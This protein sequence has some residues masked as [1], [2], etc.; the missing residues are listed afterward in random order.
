MKV[1]LLDVPF[2]IVIGG[3]CASLY[4]KHL[5]KRNKDWYVF[6]ILFF[7]VIFWLDII[8]SNSGVIPKP[9]FG[10]LGSVNIHPLIGTFYVL[11]YPLW[12][13]WGAERAFQIFGRSPEEEGVLW[14]F[15]LEEKGKPFKPSWKF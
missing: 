15:T 2:L 3:I 13:S 9:W 14:P 1:G 5:I 6:L 11:S 12:F 8:L 4:A 10:I 7:T